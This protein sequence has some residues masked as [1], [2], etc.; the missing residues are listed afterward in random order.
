VEIRAS[1]SVINAQG[2]RGHIA[3]V[4]SDD[5]IFQ[6]PADFDSR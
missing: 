2:Q 6:V 3:S 4:R 5:A 1:Q